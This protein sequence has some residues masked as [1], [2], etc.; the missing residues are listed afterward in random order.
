V[1]G[2][3]SYS[4]TAPFLAP[5][6]VLLHSG[7]Q[8]KNLSTNEVLAHIISFNKPASQIYIIKLKN[9]TKRTR[10]RVRT[11]EISDLVEPNEATVIVT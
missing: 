8:V 4:V 5:S 2:K 1:L 6:T 7:H 3:S 11:K 9:I 10:K